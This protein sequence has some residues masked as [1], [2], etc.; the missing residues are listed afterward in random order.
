MAL[1]TNIFK[2]PKHRKY[3]YI[4]RY[5]SP[6]KEELDAR[7]KRAEEMQDDGI[8]GMKSRIAYKMKRAGNTQDY[9]SHRKKALMKSNLTLLALIIGLVVASILGIM[10][11]SAEIL[12]FA[13]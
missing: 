5:Y 13:K 8:E 3:D 4:P 1:K 10:F 9:E 2:T 12:E 6:E 11:F 7:I